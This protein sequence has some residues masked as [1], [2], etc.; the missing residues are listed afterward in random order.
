M[1]KIIMFVMVLAISAPS[2][3][4]DLNPP[5]WAGAPGTIYGI[6]NF[7]V[8]APSGDT[9]PATSENREDYPE[10]GA[11]VSH[12]AHDDPC[13]FTDTSDTEGAH[14]YMRQDWTE[15]DWSWSATYQRREG[16]L[17]SEEGIG[18][19]LNNFEGSGTKLIRLQITW[20]PLPEAGVDNFWLARSNG[21]ELG[22]LAPDKRLVAEIA[23]V[24]DGWRHS[25]YE[26]EIAGN[27]SWEELWIG[28]EGDETPVDQVVFDTICYPGA[29]PPDNP[30]R[31]VVVSPIII[32]PNVSTVYETD[33]TEG[34]FDVSLRNQPPPGATITIRVDPNSIARAD[35]PEGGPSEDI[36]LIGGSLV[37]GS[38]TFTRTE[39]DWSDVTTIIFKAID[40]DIAEPPD[41]IERSKI[42]VS[43]SWPA[44]PTDANYVGEKTITARIMDND[45]ANILFTYTN[46]GTIDPKFH[47]RPGQSVKLREEPG[48]PPWSSD[49]RWRNIG[50]TLQVEPSGGPVKLQAEVVEVEFEAGG[51]EPGGDN[52]PWTDPNLL[53][54]TDN[55]H[56]ILP[57]EESDDPNGMIFT[58]GNYNVS[59]NIT[60]WGNDDDVLQIEEAF[61][62]GDEDYHAVLVVTVVDDGGDT[63]YTDLERTVEFDIEDNECG[64]F[65]FLPLD[66]GN[67]NAFTDP[68]YRDS[69]GNPLPDCY[70]DI[71]DVIEIAT[72]WLD[73]SDI[74]DPSCESYL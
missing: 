12:A 38:I 31:E 49:I 45:Q 17:S 65:G 58:A 24:G 40:D 63:R 68:N 34:N 41:L 53:P 30:G 59:R 29:E 54:G 46:E 66:V 56:F 73:C 6:W 28:F 57:F 47:I 44:H 32:D 8:E 19:T 22:P 62:E 33:E 1:K 69:D 71:Y 11:M 64:A 36:I 4:D 10:E 74:H 67:P 42:L 43:S 39:A 37:D 60:I 16:V 26:F 35:G 7:D 25:T 72:K 15:G 20:W 50:V 5:D 70:V 61:A 27:P 3:A 55:P 51:V 14:K 2:L 13:E 21:D 48:Y 9:G 23:D 52:L 18:F